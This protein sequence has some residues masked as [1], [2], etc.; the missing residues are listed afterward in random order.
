VSHPADLPMSQPPGS[1]S[2]GELFADVSRDLSELIR[3]ELALAKAEATQSATRAGAGVGMLAGAALAGF[4]LL[5]FVSMAAWW[6]LGE[7]IGRGWSA[8]I[9][10]LVW[11]VI[12]AV[13]ASQGRARLKAVKGLPQ[14]TETVKRIPNALTPDQENAR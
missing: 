1:P 13:L 12:G 10:A 5:M 4:F 6:T 8:L 14:T 11:G 9:V 3:Q 2:I 7:A